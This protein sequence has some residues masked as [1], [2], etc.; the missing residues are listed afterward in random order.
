M[1]ESNMNAFVN[2]CAGFVQ[3]YIIAPIVQH[4]AAKGVQA[5]AEELYGVLQLP[6]TRTQATPVVPTP[7]V[8]AM[9]FGGAVPK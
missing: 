9:A 6:T 1:A 7:A 8:P 2:S 5:S 3:N 4:L